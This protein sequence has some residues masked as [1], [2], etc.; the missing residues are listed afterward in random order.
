MLSSHRLFS[1][2]LNST[3]LYPLFHPIPRYS[4]L[5]SSPPLFSHPLSSSST[6]LFS[7]LLSSHP[8]SYATHLQ[9]SIQAPRIAAP[10]HSAPLDWGRRRRR[11]SHRNVWHSLFSLSSSSSPLRVLSGHPIQTL[12]TKALQ[13]PS[14]HSDSMAHT[15]SHVC[16]QRIDGGC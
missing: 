16:C 3:L 11:G 6:L 15:A 2:L 14:P 1:F 12:H 9:L 7:P 8:V 5:F 13:T 10:L 4:L